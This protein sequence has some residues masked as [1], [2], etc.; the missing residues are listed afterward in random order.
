MGCF[1][2]L[3]ILVAAVVAAIMASAV[4]V[5]AIVTFAVVAANGVGIVDQ[6]AA[7]QSG[8][9]EVCTAVGAGE[10]PDIGL[11]EGIACAAA[12]AAADE[13]INAEVLQETCKSAVA[14]TD[15]ADNFGGNDGVI[16]NGEYLELL[17]VTEML[18]D[19][20]IGVS[21][22]NFHFKASKSILL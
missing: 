12:D 21:G 17:A 18:E 4:M 13:N 22:S 10:Q 8:Y 19:L 6:S 3:W 15:C 20:A 14:A 5:A 16:L 2:A 7:E 9:A 11:S 1:A